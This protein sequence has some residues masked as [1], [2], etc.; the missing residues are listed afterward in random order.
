M[1]ERESWEYRQVDAV[2][3][4]RRE[5]WAREVRTQLA[6]AGLPMQ[7]DMQAPVG[8][9]VVVE[10]D[11]GDDRA[12]GVYVGWDTAPVLRMAALRRSVHTEERK[13]VLRHVI[14][15]EEAM[16]RA[17]RDILTTGGF[18]LGE[19]PN[20]YATGM[21]YVTRP[22]QKALLSELGLE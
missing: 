12:G 18:T 3:L 1:G 6:A 17:I 7:A 8:A 2:T 11:P 4:R 20:P 13:Q 19:N 9:G 10:V 14:A 21:L 16:T 15:V 22:P 5:A